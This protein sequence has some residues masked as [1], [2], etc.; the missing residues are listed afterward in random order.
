MSVAGITPA[1]LFQSVSDPRRLRLLRLLD[2]GELNVQEMVRI[3]DLSQPAV[4]KHLAVLKDA[5]WLRQR[6][7]GTWSWYGLAPRGEFP[8]PADLHRAVLAQAALAPEAVADDRILGEVLAERERRTGDFFAG[9]AASW[10]QIRPAFEHP[11]IQAG[12]VGALVPPG[13]SVIDIGTGTGALLPLLAATGARI[14]AVDN[15]AAMLQRA[16]ELCTAKGIADV[17]FHRADIRKLPFPD[18]SFDAAYASMVLHHIDR[19]VEAVREM[20]R[21]VRPGGKVVVMSFTSHDLTWMRDELAHR[22]LGFSPRE[23]TD[24]FAAAGLVSRRR[25]ECGPADLAVARAKL[26]AGLD[27]HSTVWPDVFL[28]VGEKRPAPAEAVAAD[29]QSA[30]GP[31]PIN[32]TP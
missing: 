12:A 3:L 11:D 6:R 10:D 24:F 17:G 27:G 29:E 31:G 9:I 32:A 15:S 13:L 7:E 20:A 18:R 19:P 16:R 2:K 21:V 26:P 8:G 30:T 14:T 23:M 1:A 28:A 25:V 5:G 22:W 4:S